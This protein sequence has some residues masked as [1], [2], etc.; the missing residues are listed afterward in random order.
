[1]TSERI[2]RADIDEVKR[3]H[4]LENL[5]YLPQEAAGILGVS[6]RTIFRLVEEGELVPANGKTASGKT[7]ITAT[8]LEIYRKKITTY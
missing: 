3:R 8:S 1:M 4:I 7:R 5:L 2:T 6:V